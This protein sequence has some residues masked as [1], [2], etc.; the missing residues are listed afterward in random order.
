MVG[1]ISELKVGIT[2]KD[3]TTG[4]LHAKAAYGYN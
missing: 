4:H 3:P 2:K 1:V